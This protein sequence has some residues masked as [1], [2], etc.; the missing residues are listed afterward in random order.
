VAGTTGAVRVVT[1]R[2][3]YTA[4]DA[5]SRVYEAHLLRRSYREDGK[6]KS[7]TVGNIS[8][9][10][11]AAIEAVR[12]VLRGEALVSAGAG[13][14][15]VLECV[16]SRAHGHLAAA[17]VIAGKLG[18]A[19][20]VGPACRERDLIMALVLAR[21]IA[22]ASKRASVVWWADTSLAVDFGVADAGTD[23]VYAAL[24]W[25]GAGQSRIEAELA[26]R[27]PRE[28]GVAPYDLSRSWVTGRCCPLAVIGHSRDGKKGTAQIE[29]GLLTD[30]DG[31]PVA[32]EVFAGNSN[33]ADPTAFHHAVDPIRQRF[34]LARLTL[35]G[36][37]RNDHQRAD[38]GS[39]RTWRAGLA[40]RAARP[41]DRQA[42]RPGRAVA[43][44]A[45]RYPRP[46]RVHPPRLP[47]RA[48]DRLMLL[49]QV[50]HVGSFPSC[51]LSSALRGRQVAAP[52]ASA[53]GRVGRT[54]VL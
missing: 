8:A 33:T 11:A 16:R 48:A 22:P 21:V 34:G 9:L 39:Q 26:A 44:L 45:V 18:L 30:P 3:R 28:D 10:P 14:A 40:D 24:D 52:A 20:L 25:L 1:T 12:A 36:G 35:V 15:Q 19:A 41:S 29:Y 31:R 6:V 42:G 54:R 49:C 4:K 51:R 32:I 17:A 46:G 2:R 27:H 50:D 47:G 38:R 37:P 13:P 53:T 23:E 7:Q 5:T 43:A